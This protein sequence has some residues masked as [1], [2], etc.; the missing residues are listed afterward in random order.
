MAQSSPKRQVHTRGQGQKCFFFWRHHRIQS[1]TGPFMVC[2]VNDCRRPDRMLSQLSAPQRVGFRGLQE[3]FTWAHRLLVLLELTQQ[4]AKCQ[5]R[6]RDARASRSSLASPAKG[7][8]AQVTGQSSHPRLGKGRPL[9]L[10]G[11]RGQDQ[12]RRLGSQAS[13]QVHGVHH[14]CPVLTTLPPASAGPSLKG[15]K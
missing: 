1:S 11:A 12:G 7:G 2:F 10:Q 15:M 5:Q 14:R 6:E 13:S 8:G 4:W 3:V 9:L